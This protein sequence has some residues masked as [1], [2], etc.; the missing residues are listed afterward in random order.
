MS[1]GRAFFDF[2]DA[3]MNRRFAVLV[4]LGMAALSG[5][6]MC[7][8][9]FDYCAPVAGPNGC[10]NCNFL[11]RRGSLFAPMD[12]STATLP[13][14]PTPAEELGAPL[15]AQGLDMGEQ[16]PEMQP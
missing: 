16:L 5:C 9:P 12:D 11:A 2:E 13:M 6:A 10:P 8:A 7:Q 1:R 14:G 4:A 15:E 3:G